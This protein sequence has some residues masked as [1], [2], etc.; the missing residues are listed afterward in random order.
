MTRIFWKWYVSM[1][2]VVWFRKLL[3]GYSK[4]QTDWLKA[5]VS[6]CQHVWLNITT[7]L[8][9]FIGRVPSLKKRIK[10][11]CV[12]AQWIKYQF[13]EVKDQTKIIAK[14]QIPPKIKNLTKK[15]DRE[16]MENQQELTM[17]EETLFIK[18]LID[19]VSHDFIKG[20]RV[21][22]FAWADFVASFLLKTRPRT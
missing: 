4:Y 14:E 9:V 19:R 22:G 3:V 21:S 5:T 6:S 7:L 8:M 20:R 11:I 10:A 16:N 1:L 18:W 17:N 2:K 15:R 12:F 13:R